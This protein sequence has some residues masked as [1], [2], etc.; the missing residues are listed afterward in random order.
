[1]TKRQLLI[2]SLDSFSNYLIELNTK[3]ENSDKHFI[4]KNAVLLTNFLG[5][6]FL[7]YLIAGIFYIFLMITPIIIEILKFT[8]NNFF[9]IKYVFL[10]P[11]DSNIVFEKM[12]FDQQILI[13]KMLSISLFIDFK[14]LLTVILIV[15]LIAVGIV[16]LKKPVKGDMPRI[17]G[18]VSSILRISCVNVQF[19][20]KQLIFAGLF[21]F[22][23]S[24]LSYFVLEKYLSFLLIFLIWISIYVL[25]WMNL[26]ELKEDKLARK[27]ILYCLFAPLSISTIAVSLNDSYEKILLCIVTIYFSLERIITTI[28]ELVE[29]INEGADIIFAWNFF[30]PE[31]CERIKIRQHIDGNV[32]TLIKH[33]F[34][35]QS[36][37]LYRSLRP[38][39]E[40]AEMLARQAIEKQDEVQ[41]SKMLL[42]NILIEK[43]EHNNL[44][45]IV[46]L[47]RDIKND[48]NNSDFVWLDIDEVFIHY[49]LK[50]DQPRYEEI[51]EILENKKKYKDEEYYILG[52]CY[53]N[54]ENKLK[55]KENFERIQFKKNYTH[56]NALLKKC[57]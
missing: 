38:D 12:I 22:I 14:T 56:L 15:L 28:Q 8:I 27:L 33:D 17:I 42:V 49:E 54:Q 7:S 46:S 39:I 36:L 20:L 35:F 53:L 25:I 18:Y 13:S 19:N 24:Y 57:D 48:Q 26:A 9:Y 45:E 30:S 29:K 50:L 10:N 23:G 1:M 41:F 4:R 40:K 47:I 6:L 55:A 5:I 34:A 16:L 52:I 3:F 51:I 11:I 32:S 43:D 31:D 21:C 2:I 44:R 37:I